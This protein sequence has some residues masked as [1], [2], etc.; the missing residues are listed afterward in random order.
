MKCGV[1]AN[2]YKP[3]TP[4]DMTWGDPTSAFYDER[5]V[6]LSQLC[7]SIGG[8]TFLVRDPRGSWI[9]LNRTGAV[10]ELNNLYSGIHH[11]PSGK[12]EVINREI[13][14]T[15]VSK[16]CLNV[17]GEIQ[18]PLGASL[19]H[20][21][22]SKFVNTWHDSIIR[23]DPR[24]EHLAEDLLLIIRHSLCNDPAPAQSLPEM[25]AAIDEPSTNKEFRFVMSWLAAI[26]Q[27]PG[28]NLQT[29]LWFKGFAKGIGKGTLNEVL[30]AIYG[31]SHK[32]IRASEL[33]KG[34]NEPLRGAIIVEADE[35]SNNRSEMSN[36]IKDITTNV[37]LTITQR[38]RD[39]IQIPNT[40]NWIFTT[41]ED[42]PLFLERNDR[43][44]VFVG[45]TSD[46]ATWK[47][48]ALAF[49]K[50][51]FNQHRDQVAAGFASILNNIKVD[52]S[53]ISYAYETPE[54]KR[55]RADNISAV[56][57][58]LQTCELTPRD[59]W[60]QAGSLFSDYYVPFQKV[61][62]PK[63]AISNLTRWGIEMKRVT[64]LWT[65][66]FE[67]DEPGSFYREKRGT[68][69]WLNQ[70]ESS[71]TPIK[72]PLKAMISRHRDD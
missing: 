26:Y 61:N 55:M 41:N 39:S 21:G 7:V 40:A 46:E 3:Y 68:Q 27:A 10:N 49:N 30:R 66:N 44:N 37:T 59:V 34:W 47:P 54:F 17:Q 4:T 72:S 65:A 43:R 1:E 5:W 33:D 9:V 50:G 56:E 51:V 29:N 20:F 67:P 36:L 24:Y 25:V 31:N 71:R 57:S 16:F 63:T 8:K 38:G 18:I 32:K 6:F 12:S 42:M 58:W 14:T 60:L 64:D 2:I 19:G 48:F 70:I 28:R 22:G 11:M 52:E 45:T 69:Y 62:F 15:Y 23:P 13:I 53:L 35:F